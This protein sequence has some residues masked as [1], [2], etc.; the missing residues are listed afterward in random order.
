[1]SIRTETAHSWLSQ[2]ELDGVRDRVPMVYVDAV[3]VRVDH[4]GRVDR[5]GLL[6]RSRPDGSISRALV[7]GRVLY[8]ETLRD[9]LWRHLAKDLGPEAAP[10]LP[11][12][13]APFT[14]VEYFP[15]PSP[16]GFVDARQH[17]VA[18]AYL[19]PV[20]GECTPPED[21]LNLAWLAPSEVLSPGVMGEM[22]GGQDR[23]VRLALA[24]SGQLP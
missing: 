21:A 8:G 1:M 10:Q 19:V 9:A 4:L 18:L 11:P 6:L 2:D 5:V 20:E 13:P 22:S 14:V 23:V 3:P 12:A 24:H 16:S 15:S 7:S 17:A